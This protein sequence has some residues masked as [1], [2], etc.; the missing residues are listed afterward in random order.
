MS[1]YLQINIASLII[2]FL[3]SF[4]PK[5]KFYKKWNSFIPAMLLAAIPY[6][7]WD[8]IFAASGVW[9]FNPNYLSG[10]YLLNLPLEEVLFFICIPYASVFTHYTLVK[11]LP[12]IA[13]NRSISQ[14]ISSLLIV[15]L[16]SMII[17][18]YDKSY[19]LVNAA[20]ALTILAI[21]LFFEPKIL[22]HFYLTFLIVLI[23][24]FV[25]NGILTGS[26]ITDEVV[27]YATSE[28]MNI[29]LGTIPIED[30]FYAFSLLLLNVFITEKAPFLR[31][32]PSVSTN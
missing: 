27:W 10:I 31:R 17:L 7:I 9:G 28:N 16:V 5:I 8:E 21:V 2:P 15:A 22:Q 1:L 3:F 12:H 13:L 30:T 25:V 6:L 18:F 32:T 14:L 26:I 20:F 23:P 19:T 11:M 4:H 24:F 29:R